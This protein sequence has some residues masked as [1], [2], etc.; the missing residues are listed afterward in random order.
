MKKM[1]KLFAAAAAAL[2]ACLLAASALAASYGYAVIDGKS[3]T[4]VHLREEPS[5]KAASL[6]LFFTGTEVE[7]RSDPYGEWIKVRIEGASGY[8]HSAYLSQGSAKEDVP[9]V[10]WRGAITAKNYTNF[11]RGP[12]TEFNLVGTIDAGESVKIMGQT[13]DGWYYVQ[14]KG[15]WGYVAENLLRV[16][17]RSVERDYEYDG[18]RDDDRYGVCEDWDDWHD[19]EDDWEDDWEEDDD[20]RVTIDDL[21]I[22]RP[23]A[24]PKPTYRPRPTAT[25]KPVYRPTAQPGK[26][27]FPHGTPEEWIHLS[28]AG[29]WCTEMQMGKDG[30]FTGYYHDSEADVVYESSFSGRFTNVRK[31]DSYSYTMTLFALDI[32]GTENVAYAKDG[33]LYITQAPAGL[34]AGDTYVLYL[35]GTPKERLTEEELSWLHDDGGS[36]LDT[37]FLCSQ[38][39]GRGFVPESAI[40]ENG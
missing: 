25:P 22:V 21:I 33:K 30:S 29:A 24:T 13:A 14:Y 11:R 2:L 26:S 34:K 4:K 20:D 3:A 15:D 39:T 31:R 35:P 19:W 9:E 27:V 36:T 23:T 37:F 18:S 32:D 12:S 6:G 16:S 1:K 7:I 28:G 38:N 40:E 17:D 10:Y 8:I 5:S